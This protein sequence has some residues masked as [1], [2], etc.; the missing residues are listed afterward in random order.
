MEEEDLPGTPRDAQSVKTPPTFKTTFKCSSDDL[1]TV[2][3]AVGDCTLSDSAEEAAASAAA[4]TPR[5]SLSAGVGNKATNCSGQQ[6]KVYLTPVS[7]EEILHDHED[8]GRSDGVGIRKSSSATTEP[9]P[10]GSSMGN[11]RDF[12][13]DGDVHQVRQENS[14]STKEKIVIKKICM[15]FIF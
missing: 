15:C 8:G 5:S 1:D 14:S 13:T 6:K 11:E 12:E 3:G 9:I 7:P 10:I 2:F 4:S